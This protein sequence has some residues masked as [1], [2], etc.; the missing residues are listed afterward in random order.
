MT[1]KR[2]IKIEQIINN[3]SKFYYATQNSSVISLI[4]PTKIED[5]HIDPNELLAKNFSKKER[6][7]ILAHPQ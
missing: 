1:K 7:I 3:P 2:K 4:N 6:D 5:G